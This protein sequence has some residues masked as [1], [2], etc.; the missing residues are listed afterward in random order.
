MNATETKVALGV[1]STVEDAYAL[2]RDEW[3]PIVISVARYAAAWDIEQVAAA[4][5][6]GAGHE[7]DSALGLFA[8][9][10]AIEQFPDDILD[11]EA[12]P[13]DHWRSIG[14]VASIIYEAIQG[15]RLADG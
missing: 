14:T 13:A 7:I 5:A 15:H 12:M 2:T 11:V 8:V 9:V 1:P 3:I 4:E 6:D 10:L